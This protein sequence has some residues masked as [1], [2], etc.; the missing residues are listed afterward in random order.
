[1]SKFTSLLDA[2]SIT[3][4]FFKNPQTMCLT[5]S[6]FDKESSCNWFVVGHTAGWTTGV[7]VVGSGH[8]I[9]QGKSRISTLMKSWT[10]VQTTHNFWLIWIGQNQWFQVKNT[11]EN[12]LLWWGGAR[13][14]DY[15]SL[16]LFSFPIFLVEHYLT[17]K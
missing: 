8:Y 7:L 4:F 1:M 2:P 17:F 12:N 11:K 13:L 6:Q 16:N 14:I 15:D 9:W 3:V 5:I 10:E